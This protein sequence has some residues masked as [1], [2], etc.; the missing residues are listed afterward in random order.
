MF[1]RFSP[2]GKYL[3]F[4]GQYDGNT[5]VYL[6]PAEGGTPKRLTYTATLGRDD[7]SDRMGPNNIVMAW[8]PDGKNIL[9]R[10]R[11]RSFNDF[12]GQLFTVSID[13]GIPEQLPLPRGGFGSYSPDGA[14]LAYNPVFREFPPLKRY[15]RGMPAQVVTYHSQPTQLHHPP[16]HP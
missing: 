10:S 1:A 2:D 4:T 14:K 5:E 12:I 8:T 7:V 9:F 16:P 6:M 15:P 3:A 13:G 11:M